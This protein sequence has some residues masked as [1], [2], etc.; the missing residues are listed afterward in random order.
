MRPLPRPRKHDPTTH[1]TSR[2]PPP[3]HQRPPRRPSIQLVSDA[4]VAGY[5]HAI[6]ARH[7]SAHPDK[8][9]DVAEGMAA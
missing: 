6:S 2:P 5:S 7:R 4:V 9:F 8:R 3:P 1:D